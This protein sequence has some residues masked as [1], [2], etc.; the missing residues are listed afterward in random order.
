MSQVK[1]HMFAVTDLDIMVIQLT[2]IFYCLANLHS[3]SEKTMI[4]ESNS[5][6]PI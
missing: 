2:W 5:L 4:A 3:Q 1:Y 6:K